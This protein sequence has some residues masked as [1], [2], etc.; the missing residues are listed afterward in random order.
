MKNALILAVLLFSVKTTTAQ[1][2][3]SFP[4]KEF[5]I[6]FGPA[7]TNI[8]STNLSF[9][10]YASTKGTNWFTAGLQYSKYFNKNMGFLIGIE[11]S[12]YQNVTTYKGAFRSTE[13]S[14]DSD[15]YYYYKVSEA[16]YTDKRTVNSANVPIGLRIQVPMKDKAQFFIDMGVTL[17]FIASAKIEEKGTLNT[18]GAY[19]NVNYDN[20]FLYVENDPYYGY[21]DNTYNSVIDIPVRRVNLSYFIGAGIKAKIAD[22][23]YILISPT[24]CNGITDFV[25]KDNR[26]SY[27]NVFGE[28][29]PYTKFSLTQMALKIGVVFEI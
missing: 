13:K 25:N 21:K 14:V 26:N 17:N 24:Y 20:V 1:D 3:K 5:S 23:K 22:Y 18:K 29:S 28:K 16:N 15:G 27:T 12:K 6:F 9:D 4:E 11:Y 10:Q 19:P 8:K 7:F 2:T